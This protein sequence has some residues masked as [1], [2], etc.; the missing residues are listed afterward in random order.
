MLLPNRIQRWA[1]QGGLTIAAALS[2]LAGTQAAVTQAQA[3]TI[4]P[5]PVSN[6]YSPA[7]HHSYR[8]GVIP[9]TAVAAKMRSWAKTHPNTIQASANDLNYGGGIDGI[10]VT[11]GHEKVYLV[12]YGSQWGT[13]GSDGSGNVTFVG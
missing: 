3:A 10:G 8:H 4:G 1:T 6:P 12:F 2:L 13:Q 9:T 7:Y 11:T 5:A